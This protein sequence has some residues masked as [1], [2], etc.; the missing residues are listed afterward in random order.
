MNSDVRPGRAFGI[1]IG[2]VLMAIAAYAAWH[3]R[4]TTLVV[5]GGL[6]LGLVT[7]GVT[8][9]QL[10]IGPARHWMRFARVLGHI[11]TRVL[12]TAAF[13]LVLLPM[14]LAWRLIGRDPLGRRRNRWPGWT[15][16]PVRYRDR[17]HFAR[18]F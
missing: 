1:S 8:F 12:L 3:G 7:L 11:N 5:S 18:M 4:M 9:P 14:G 17:S 10:L 6:G 2:T 13:V 15:P 16:P